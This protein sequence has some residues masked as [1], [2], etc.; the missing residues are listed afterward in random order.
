MPAES[1]SLEKEAE[2][3]L[4]FQELKDIRD[5]IAV[6]NNGQAEVVKQHKPSEA[7]SAADLEKMELPPLTYLVNEIL[8]QGGIAVLAAPPKSY[9]SF[10]VLDML[11]SITTGRPFLGFQTTKTAALYYDLESGKRRPRDRLKTILQGK[12]FPRDLYIVTAETKPGTMDEGFLEDMAFHLEEHPEIRLIV[13]DVFQK[14]RGKKS[15]SLNAYEADYKELSELQEFAINHGV[16][17]FF[18]TH[19]SQKE[20]ADY[21]NMFTGSSG[22]TGSADTL[23]F[24]QKKRKEQEGVLRITGKDARPQDLSINWQENACRWRNMGDADER[25][26]QLALERR[27]QEYNGSMIPRTIKALLQ[28]NGGKWAGTSEEIRQASIYL[29]NG[30]AITE[31]CRG[32]GKFISNNTDLLYAVDDIKTELPKGGGRDGR[33]YTFTCSTC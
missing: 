12:P 21:L 1:T 2:T 11:C 32:V 24:I 17:L 29:C 8:P 9:K 33:K 7:I 3:L 15:R 16:T 28:Q 31:N 10:L 4:F 19:T 20:S 25:A 14:I 6:C 23:W 13:I 22:I 30:F 18:L 26:E 5:G 27:N